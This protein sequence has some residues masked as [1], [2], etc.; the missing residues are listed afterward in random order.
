MH[1]CEG[2]LQLRL[3]MMQKNDCIRNDP[4]LNLELSRSLF[5]RKRRRP[6]TSRR[7]GICAA[8]CT[9]GSSTRTLSVLFVSCLL[10]CG[11]N[12]NQMSYSVSAHGIQRAVKVPRRQ[13]D[14]DNHPFKRDVTAQ[15]TT[16]RNLEFDLNRG[17]NEAQPGVEIRS[18][19]VPPL[20]ILLQNSSV[21]D[22]DFDLEY[23]YMQYFQ[24]MTEYNTSTIGPFYLSKTYEMPVSSDL[25]DLDKSSGNDSIGGHLEHRHNYKPLRLV[26]F[27]QQKYTRYLTPHQ[28]KVL[29]DVILEP[30]LTA[31]SDSLHTVP[32]REGTRLT[33]DPSQLEDGQYCGAAIEDGESPIERGDRV[34]VPSKHIEEGVKDA[35]TVIYISL[36]FS[37]SWLE[38]QLLETEKPFYMQESEAEVQE[39]VADPFAVEESEAIEG[40]WVR[41]RFY[42]ARVPSI[43]SSSSLQTFEV[44]D[45]LIEPK[46]DGTWENNANS[47]KAKDSAMS[48]GATEDAYGEADPVVVVQDEQELKNLDNVSNQTSSQS[49]SIK[50]ETM[51]LTNTTAETLSALPPPP[52]CAHPSNILASASFCNTD[53]YDRPVAGVLHICISDPAFFHEHSVA[54]KT[55]LH[56][57]AHILGF[58]PISLAHFRFPDG[59]P[60]TERD[61]EGNVPMVDTICTGIETNQSGNDAN[62]QEIPI[63]Q[64][65]LPSE[66]VLRFSMKR[67]GVRV[68]EIV[69]E[70]VAMVARSEL[71]F[72]R[73]ATSKVSSY[74]S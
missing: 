4:R 67:T 1:A 40:D 20:S 9:M 23:Q 52:A 18:N 22:K 42:K 66:H 65:P 56:E 71:I 16:T 5:L 7:G 29:T 3:T 34:L 26:A 11:R 33:L 2:R 48:I 57:L 30:A 37:E 28:L 73:L 49:L 19:V 21:A 74:T 39:E 24:N 25:T 55:V 38:L 68:A 69:T 31:W 44:T 70:T 47:T 58:N 27:M 45:S 46:E 54:T 8:R 17:L 35:D 32:V 63:I 60:M 72:Y 64:Q 13:I 6:R 50:N 41:H 36:G 43:P 14:Y 59:S 61:D 62:N 10:S 53:Q 15:N 51:S 12:N